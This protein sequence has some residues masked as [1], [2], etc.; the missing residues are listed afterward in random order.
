MGSLFAGTLSEAHPG[1][2]GKDHCHLCY[3]ACEEHGLSWGAHHCHPDRQP[4]EQLARPRLKKKQQ[5]SADDWGIGTSHS[6]KVVRV[7]AGDQLTVESGGQR[8]SINLFGIASPVHGQAYSKEALKFTSKRARR[9]KVTLIVQDRSGEET[10]SASVIL[11]DGQNL[12]HLVLQN[13]WAWWDQRAS[14]ELILQILSQEARQEKRGLW[15]DDDPV[16][17]WNYQS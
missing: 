6:G 4:G 14:N 1:S 9:K 10:V 13:G 11:P 15:K 8:Y 5:A 12:N 16:P 7:S 3:E 17:P 2:V